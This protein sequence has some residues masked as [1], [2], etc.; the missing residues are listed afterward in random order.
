MF[1]YFFLIGMG[2]ATISE[3]NANY[4]LLIVNYLTK[5]EYLT[6]F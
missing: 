5:F 1:K 4:L 6:L 2:I 3:R